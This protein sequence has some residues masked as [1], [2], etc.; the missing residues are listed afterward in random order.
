MANTEWR[1]CRIVRASAN[2]ERRLSRDKAA[3]KGDQRQ[4]DNRDERVQGDTVTRSINGIDAL[5]RV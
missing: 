1:K 5:P 2:D 4:A 3:A